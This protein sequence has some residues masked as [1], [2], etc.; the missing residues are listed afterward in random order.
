VVT[1]LGSSPTAL[2]R[3]LEVLRPRGK[4]GRL[5]RLAP[6]FA[7]RTEATLLGRPAAEPLAAPVA[8]VTV[9]RVG[10]LLRFDPSGSGLSR[11]EFLSRALERMESGQRV[12]SRGDGDRLLLS[13]SLATGPARVRIAD[14]H[15]DLEVA[16]GRLLVHDLY[17]HPAAA[18]GAVTEDFLRG[19]LSAALKTPDVS[20]IDAIID[21][22]DAAKAVFEN[23]GFLPRRALGTR[24]VL[25]HRRRTGSSPA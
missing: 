7:A 21:R 9:N 24:R 3:G 22:H 4:G 6:L 5:A 19:V 23:L 20:G 16:P 14:L 17:R 10:D 13:C 25:W 11:R 1:G 18:E 15:Q 12:C 8:P 2:R